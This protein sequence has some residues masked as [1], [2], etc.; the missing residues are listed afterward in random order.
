MKMNKFFA[1]LLMGLAVAAC[2]GKP[3]GDDIP[4]EF[5]PSKAQIDSVSYLLGVNF[6]SYLRSWDFGPDLNYSA[7]IKGMKDFVN[8]E[9]DTMD[10]DFMKQFKVD[11]KEMDRLFNSYLE[12]RRTAVAKSNKAKSDKF[13]AENG[14][15]SGV[16]TTETGLQYKIIESGNDVKP[17]PQDT[18][19]VRYKGTLVD[20]TVF[21][22]VAED[23]EPIRLMLN[24]VVPGWTE[25]LQLIGE[26]GK[27]EL[28]IPSELGYGD[29]G[30]QAIGPNSALIFKVEMTQVGKYVEPVVDEE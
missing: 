27:I 17:G 4:K 10:P 22:E 12:N 30:N 8:A 29:A 5:R 3:A 23:E 19:W 11:P 9:G 15:R 13:L 21:D 7:I 16:V 6:G 2:S 1:V 25:G 14:K 28:Y 20:G 24:R 26:G 18:V